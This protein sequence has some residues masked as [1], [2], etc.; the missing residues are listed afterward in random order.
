MARCVD[1]T[2]ILVVAVYALLPAITD[3]ALQEGFYKSNT[4]CTVDVEAT[5]ASVVQRYISADRGVGAAGSSALH[6]HDCFVKG[7]DGSVLIDPSPINPDPEKGSPSNGGL[8]GSRDHHTKPSNSSR[9]RARGP[10][11][12]PTSSPS[13]RGDASNILSAGAIN[14]GVP[15]GRRDG[16]TSAASD[17]TQSLPPPFAQLARLTELFAA[18]GFSQD[19][20]V[21][22]SGAHSVG[23]AHCGAFS[24]RIRP[25]VSDTMDADYGARLQQ[26]CGDDG[27]GVAVDQDQGTPVDLDNVYYRNVLAG[28]VLFNS[29]WALVSDNATRQMVEENAA[30]Q[31]QWAAKFI[32]AMRK[33]GELEVLTGDE[34]EIRRFCNVT[35]SG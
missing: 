24:E 14:Y 30:D 35:N 33:M 27:D 12:A 8:R 9:A 10:S 7:C 6:F 16:L 13:P 20:L 2:L 18:K 5:V 19:E 1:A 34:G 3:A 11:P 29:D 28:K 25:N 4:N 32:D 21:T 17:A 26:Q 31:A 15:S 23:R 22:L